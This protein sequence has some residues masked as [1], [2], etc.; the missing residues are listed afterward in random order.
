MY[1]P[2]C[3]EKK[4][5]RHLIFCDKNETNLSKIDLRKLYLEYNYPEIATYENLIKHYVDYR[6][7]LPDIHKEFGIDY[8]STK[9]LLDYYKIIK[10][11]S[12]EASIVSMNKREKT[13]L[14]KYGAKNVL[15]KGTEKYEKRNNTIKEKYGVDNAFQIKEVIEKIND[16]DYYMEKYGLTKNKLRSLNSKIMWN[17]MSPDEKL[18]FL[19][20]SN[21]N[22][23]QTWNKKYGGHP[24]NNNEIKKKIIEKN[25]DKYGCDYFFQSKEFLENQEIKIKS[26]ETSILNGYILPDDLLEPFDRYKRTCRKLTYRIKKEIFENWNGYDYYDGEYIKDYLSLHNLDKKYPTIDHKISIFY[27]FMNNISEEEICSI[28]NLCITKRSINSAKRTKTHEDISKNR[29]TK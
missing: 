3:K 15:S 25:N 14:E 10:R 18:Q 13:N 22:R 4:L 19:Y 6:K 1:C 26:K 9:F 28:D 11:N 8:N 12:S 21:K 20:I 23:N 17:K 2:F 29:D 7:S 16:D 24:L 27:G 5:N